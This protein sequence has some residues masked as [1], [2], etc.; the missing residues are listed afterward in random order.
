MITLRIFPIFSISRIDRRTPF[1]ACVAF[2]ITLPITREIVV[3]RAPLTWTTLTTQGKITAQGDGID[4]VGTIDVGAALKG[5]LII[6]VVVIV[7]AV[8]TFRIIIR[9]IGLL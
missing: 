1:T 2:M 6:V 3:V 9:I 8:V 4:V 7:V 5:L